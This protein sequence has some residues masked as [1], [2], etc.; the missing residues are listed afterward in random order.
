MCQ[1]PQAWSVYVYACTYTLGPG[2]YDLKARLTCPVSREALCLYMLD[3]H[4]LPTPA[5]YAW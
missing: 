2:M 4:Y 1:L 5:T 3:H